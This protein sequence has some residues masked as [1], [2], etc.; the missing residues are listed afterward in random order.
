MEKLLEAIFEQVKAYPKNT[1]A[2]TDLYYMSKDAIGTDVDLGVKYLKLLSE[3]LMK[4]IPNSE[5]NT[6]RTLFTLHKKVLLAAAPYDFDSYLLYI[7]WERD[8]DKKFYPPR[9]RVL[10]QVVDALQE[11]A[12]RKI[13]LLTISSAWNGKNH[14]CH[15]LSHVDCRT[16]SKRAESFW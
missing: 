10:K 9:R 13:E 8:P 12:E 1:Q 11:L 7:E 5:G 6:L 3:Q 14:A 16:K 4:N 2:A 15:L